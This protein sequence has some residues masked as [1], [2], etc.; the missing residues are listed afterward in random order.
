MKQDQYLDYS[1]NLIR[2][3][4]LVIEIEQSVNSRQFIQALEE[5]TELCVEARNMK[6][7][8]HNML[9]PPHIVKD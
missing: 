1:E 9:P 5:T 8:M 2:I 6:S 7:R 4:Q 3:K